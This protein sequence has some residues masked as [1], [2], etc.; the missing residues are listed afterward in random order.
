MSDLVQSKHLLS[1]FLGYFPTFHDDE[2][3][4]FILDAR[5]QAVVMEILTKEWTNQVDE[6]GYFISGKYGIVTI[7]FEKV[8]ELELEVELNNI[9]LEMK[10]KRQGDYILTDIYGTLGIGGK[11]VSKTV[12]IVSVKEIEKPI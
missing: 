4:S 12:R 11:I 2:V 6:R 8:S 9:I 7:Q 1:D 3:Q 10:F 5:N